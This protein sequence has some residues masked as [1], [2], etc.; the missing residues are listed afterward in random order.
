M[1]T[2]IKILKLGDESQLEAYL[3][4][5]LDSS[6]FLLGNLRQAGLVD[7]GERYAGTYAAT[8]TDGQIAGVVAHYGQGNLLCQAP[9]AQIEALWR[10]AVDASQRPIHGV[11]GPAAQVGVIKNALDV[12]GR[13]IQMDA[14]EHLYRLTLSQ[15]QLPKP[16]Q[17]G[18]VVG[19]QIERQD[20]AQMIE[21]RI[22]YNIEASGAEDTPA[23][24]EACR[25]GMERVLAEGNGWVLEVDRQNVAYSAFNTTLSEAVQ[26]G[27]VWTP[28][29]FR[30][31]GYARAVVATSLLDAQNGGIEK[32]VLFTDNNNIPAQKAYES[33]GFQRI[34]DYCLL[35]F[36]K[37]VSP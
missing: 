8:V 21:W 31:R 2:Q 12:E 30:G 13:N 17:S 19:R 23:L 27:G 22:A 11:V 18:D 4:P 33:L 26:I 15:M 14:T 6:M 25:S 34:G 20:L 10:A 29:E 24:H 5:R 3:L 32:A 16:Y 1:P 9:P 36:S 28:P 7:N 37:P 35:I